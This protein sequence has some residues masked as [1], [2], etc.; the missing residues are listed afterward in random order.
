MMIAVDPPD[1]ARLRGLVNRGFTPRRIAA[2]EPRVRELAVGYLEQAL[3]AG[4][5]EMELIHDFAVPTP[6]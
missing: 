1:H 5:G 6:W 4:G 3:E 2:L